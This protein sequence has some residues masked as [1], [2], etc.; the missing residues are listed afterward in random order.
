MDADA[1]GAGGCAFG[2]RWVGFALMDIHERIC[3]LQ[4]VLMYCF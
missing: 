2:F 3:G 4:L 1:G